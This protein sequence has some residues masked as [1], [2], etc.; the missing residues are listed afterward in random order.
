MMKMRGGF[1]G[2]VVGATLRQVNNEV[3]TCLCVR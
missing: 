1:D 3:V 2:I